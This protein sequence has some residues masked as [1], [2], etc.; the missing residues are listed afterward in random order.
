MARREI[1]SLRRVGIQSLE[2]RDAILKKQGGGCAICGRPEP[3]SSTKGS[4]AKDHWH[5][6]PNCES[7][8]PDCFRGLLC[9]PCNIGIGLMRDDIDVLKKAIKYLRKAEHR[10]GY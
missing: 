8:C 9:G 1:Y 2:E 4:W 10:T 3:D 6:C 7:G 5:G